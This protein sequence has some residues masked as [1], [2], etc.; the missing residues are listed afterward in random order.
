MDLSSGVHLLVFN[1]MSLAQTVSPRITFNQLKG[2]C[3]EMDL[4]WLACID[5]SWP[6]LGTRQVKLF[7]R[8]VRF[9]KIFYNYCISWH[10]PFNLTFSKK[11]VISINISVNKHI[12]VNK[13]LSFESLNSFYYLKR[14]KC[15]TDISL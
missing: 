10:R 13:L 8:S 4:T 12:K 2:Q 11:Y 14:L 1:T 6:K 7:Q 5:R 15:K 9:V 3:H